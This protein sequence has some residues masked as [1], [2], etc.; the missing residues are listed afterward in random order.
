MLVRE[1]YF[2]YFLKFFEVRIFSVYFVNGGIGILKF[3]VKNIIDLKLC[4]FN[5]INVYVV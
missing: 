1:I 4:Y 3:I 5:F 2:I